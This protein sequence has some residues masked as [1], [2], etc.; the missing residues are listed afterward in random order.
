[1]KLFNS[2]HLFRKAFVATKREIFASLMILL[3][4]TVAF[5]IV[6]WLSEK[7]YNS[8]YSFIDALVWIVVK[9]VE[10]P[11]D[12]ATPPVTFLGQIVGTMV[13]VLGVAI[14]AVPAGLIGSGLLD[15]ME[16]DKNKEKLAVNSARLH[17]RFRRI[18]QSASWIRNKEGLKK[19][20]TFVPRYRTYEHIQVRTGMTDAEIV[21][22]VRNCPDMRL[23]DLGSTQRDDDKQ[24]SGLAVAHFPLNNE[25]GCYID[26][27][28]DVTIVAPV[29]VTE[30][31][32]GHFAFSLAAMGGFNYVSK[33][34]APNPDDPFGFYSMKKSNLALIG[35]EKMKREVEL[36]AMHF[37]DDLDRL[38]QKSEAAGRRHWFIFVMGTTK[39]VDYQVHFWRLATDKSKTLAHRIV[40][41]AEY[42]STVLEESE[43]VMQNIFTASKEALAKF[44]VT[45]NSNKQPVE[46]CMDNENILK[47][48]LPSNIMRRVGGGS[49]CNAFTLRVGYEILMFHN[50]HL[51]IVKEIADIIR[52][53]VEPTHEIP[54]EAIKCFTKEGDGFADDYNSN[55]VFEHNPEKL[56]KMIKMCKKELEYQYKDRY[57][58]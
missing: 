51:L 6:M 12:V 36:Q 58:M 52:A 21:E 43:E 13:G 57:I 33:E 55:E 34:L 3:L 10:D 20:L 25:Y 28:S 16:D 38:K 31:G 5:T 4:I 53:Q 30:P 35:D 39:S 24:Q 2:F 8:N 42:G 19:T 40:K 1:M 23:V 48:V 50:I 17:K 49:S 18:S 11:A 22:T 44:E 47:G 26:R 46:V 32:T 37:L 15:A 9:Y 41:C 27:S 56:K 7:S 54:A 14:F 45:I 29:A